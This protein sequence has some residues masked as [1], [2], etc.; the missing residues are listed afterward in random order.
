VYL[1][2]WPA[3][4]QDKASPLEVIIYCGYW[5]II[6]AIMALRSW[7]GTLMDADYKYNQSRR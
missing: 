4:P 3:R 1:G 2:P 7:R 6:L 5:C